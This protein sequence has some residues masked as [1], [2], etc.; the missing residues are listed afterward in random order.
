MNFLNEHDFNNSFTSPRRYFF[1]FF[2]SHSSFSPSYFP[3]YFPFSIV[4]CLTHCFYT[5]CC[6]ILY[7]YIRQ[8]IAGIYL[9]IYICI[10][11]DM[12]IYF[13]CNIFGFYR[14]FNYFAHVAVSKYRIFHHSKYCHSVYNTLYCTTM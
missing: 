5:T 8:Q 12:R 6:P 13:W 7:D 1:L 14:V 10:Y 2:F 3:L 11:V 9:H 4:H